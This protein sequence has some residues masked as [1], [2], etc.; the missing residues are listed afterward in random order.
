MSWP[1][2]VDK[3]ER[4]RER[5]SRPLSVIGV[6]CS[7]VAVLALLYPGKGL[8]GVLDVGEDAATVRYREAILRQHPE[9]TGLRVSVADSLVRLGEFRR[10][11]DLLTP[12]PGNLTDAQLSKVIELRYLAVR[13]LFS[14]A[15]RG[16][17]E[18]K[19]LR[20]QFVE[21]ADRYAGDRPD[22]SRLRQLAADARSAG[23]MESWQAL[24]A[25]ADSL[26][27]QAVPV[28]PLSEALARGD[29]RGAAAIC[30]DAMSRAESLQQRRALFMQGVK[31][32]Q[33]G[34]LPL[35]ALDEGERH[36]EELAGDRITLMFLTRVA[37]AA[38]QPSRA[39]HIIRRALGMGSDQAKARVP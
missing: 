12:L 4:R 9:N 19:H 26:E 22:L 7:F 18:W 2:A 11:L 16:N 1:S 8:M 37:L 3:R 29:Y 13:S 31:I 14:L 24:Q 6:F 25:R 15:G 20:R 21:A 32:L 39:Q 5:F 30:F 35:E 33:S 38:N 28:S 27:P 36:L 23:D 34:N 10:A 17:E